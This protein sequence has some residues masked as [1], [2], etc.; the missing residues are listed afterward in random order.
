MGSR[1]ARPFPWR[2][3][4]F[5]FLGWTFDFYDLVLLGFVK[6]PVARDLHLTPAAEPWVLGVALS[7]SGIGGIVSGALADRFGKRTLLAATVLL[8]S[9][10]SLVSGLAPNLAVFLVGRAI[11]G[12]G[13][14]GEWA[15]GHGMLAEAVEARAARARVGGAAGGRAGR[16]RARGVRGVPAGADRRVARRDDRLE[17]DGASSRS[18][19]AES[20][21]LPTSPRRRAPVMARD[22]ASARGLRADAGAARGSSACSSWAPTGLATRGSRASSRRRYIR[23]VGLARL[24]AHRAGRASSGDADLRAARRP[25]SGG[26]RRSRSFSLLT[27]VRA[28]AARLRVGLAHVARALLLARDARAR[29][30]LGL[31]R[32]LRRAARRALPDEVRARRWARPTTARARRSSSRRSSCT[33]R[34][35]P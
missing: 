13:V 18:S 26:G 23:P 4:V 15:I 31:H 16:R 28:H 30:R 1:D 14:G 2:L 35:S 20:M 24:D 19:C 3:F 8:Y 25:A 5:A 22:P 7:T 9:L 12:L 6:E 10:G 32:G 29:R 34:S 33:P 11:V 17:R 27:G 21:H